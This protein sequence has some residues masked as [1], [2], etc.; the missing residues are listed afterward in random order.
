LEVK[1]EVQRVTAIR[2]YARISLCLPK[3]IKTTDTIKE[4]PTIEPIMIGKISMPS[5]SHPIIPQKLP[6]QTLSQ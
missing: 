3:R 4:M 6:S 5:N 2:T 1:I